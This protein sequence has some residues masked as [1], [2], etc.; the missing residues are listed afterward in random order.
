M[1]QFF[2]LGNKDKFNKYT[3]IINLELKEN[4]KTLLSKI[5]NYFNNTIL[6]K[7]EWVN[8]RELAKHLIYHNTYDVLDFTKSGRKTFTRGEDGVYRSFV[9]FRH[10]E[11]YIRDNES[12]VY[13]FD[14]KKCLD[15]Y[16]HYLLKRIPTK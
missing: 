7:K 8:A 11:E 16:E 14:L 2:Y 15:R 3:N 13:Y 4:M 6:D 12:G 1:W 10:K 9:L 5:K